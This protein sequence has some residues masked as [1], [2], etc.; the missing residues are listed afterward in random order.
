M[1]S[2]NLLLLYVFFTLIKTLKFQTE[3]H[4]N[5]AKF[6]L[7]PT[8]QLEMMDGKNRYELLRN[9]IP[10]YGDCWIKAVEELHLGCKQLNE[11]I[12]SR[13]AFSFA[14]CFLLKL[15]L[16]IDPCPSHVDIA[17][18]MKDMNERIFTSYTEF[19]THTQSICFF[20]QSQVWQ[21]EVEGTVRKLS[22][23]SKRLS[24]KLELASEKQM[25]IL[26]LQSVSLDEQQKMLKSGNDLNSQIEKSRENIKNVFQELKST[27]QEHRILIFEVF[28]QINKLN[29]LILGGFVGFYTIVFYVVSIFVSYLLTSTTRTQD[30]RLWLFII[31]TLNCIGEQ[32]ICSYSMKE[33]SE[34]NKLLQDD[35]SI[36]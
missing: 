31:M 29:A 17:E 30:A 32:I 28:E 35:V 25:E 3:D 16:K 2:R 14:R 34:R 6:E 26:K 1:S 9:Q 11:E 23:T 21:N 20:L 10:L 15:G 13:L 24:Y 19:F 8:Q 18:C 7:L 36:L 12:Q 22:A 4:F 27:T 5:M 33:E